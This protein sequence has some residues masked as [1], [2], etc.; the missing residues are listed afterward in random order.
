[1]NGLPYFVFAIKK[2][3]RKGLAYFV[4][5]CSNAA[6]LSNPNEIATVK[7]WVRALSAFT[8][9]ASKWKGFHSVESRYLQIKL[10][11]KISIIN[12]NL[13]NLVLFPSH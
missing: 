10:K 4:L 11:L 2:Y 12:A 1:M 5:A 3:Y 13:A 6:S 9:A 7:F 8:A